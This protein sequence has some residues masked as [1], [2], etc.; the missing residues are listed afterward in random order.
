MARSHSPRSFT[1]GNINSS[2]YFLTKSIERSI[3][4]PVE[5]ITSEVPQRAGGYAVRSELGMREFQVTV[6]LLAD[7]L[8]ELRSK[9][10]EIAA[11]LFADEDRQ[12]TFSDEPNVYYLA[13]LQGDTAFDELLMYGETT[14]N[15]LC[16]DPIG[17]STTELN[18]LF[19]DFVNGTTYKVGGTFETF[20]RVRLVPTAALTYIRYNLGTK[21][22]LLNGSFAAW[23]AIIVDH[24]TNSVYMESTGER[25]MTTLDI[26]SDFF[27]FKVGDNLLTAEPSSGLSFRVYWRERYL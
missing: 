17:Y 11:W 7:T 24:E 10:R 5:V 8:A 15:F 12:L 2:Q 26:S 18:K 25:I 4:P 21:H 14:L 16:A 9:I 6:T 23:A 19:E 22:I 1:F 27:P 13:R 3:L 20:P